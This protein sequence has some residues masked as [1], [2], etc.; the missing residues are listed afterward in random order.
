[1][2]RPHNAPDVFR[3]IAHPIRRRMLDMLRKDALTASEL[4]QPFRMTMSSVSEHIGTLR[5][6]GL[7]ESRPRGPHHVYTLVR[8]RL[9]PIEEWVLR[10]R[11]DD[12]RAKT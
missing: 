12:H 10:H 2:A 1:M 9:R 5:G 3:A 4:A 7:I 8:G 11:S 6:A